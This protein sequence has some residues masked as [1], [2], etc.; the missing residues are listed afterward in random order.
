[1]RPSYRRLQQYAIAI[2]VLSIF[3]NG[4]EGGVSIGFGSESSSRS[5][6]FFGVQ[7]G[8]EVLSACLV[9][10]RFKKIA[11]PGEERGLSLGPKELR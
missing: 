10:W 11:A 1:M 2:S 8:L 6:F 9:V 3:Y 4:A 5:L 7:S